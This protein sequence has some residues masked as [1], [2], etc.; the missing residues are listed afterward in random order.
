MSNDGFKPAGNTPFS[1]LVPETREMDKTQSKWDKECAM[2][3]KLFECE[4]KEKLGVPCVC[5]EERRKIGN[6]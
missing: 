5:Y 3:R 1:K 2:C 6:R 4:G